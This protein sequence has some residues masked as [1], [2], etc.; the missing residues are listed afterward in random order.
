MNLLSIE[1]VA[2]EMDKEMLF[3][4][5]TQRGKCLFQ[6]LVSKLADKLVHWDRIESRGRKTVFVQTEDGSCS[7]DLGFAL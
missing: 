1:L 7:R 5:D 6:S 3:M 4:S 2:N